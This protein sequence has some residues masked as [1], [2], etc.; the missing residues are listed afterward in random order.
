[1]NEKN[2]KF[3]DKK[4]GKRNFYKNKNLFKMEY[5]DINK[6]LVSKKASYGKESI[7]Y[8]IEDN[9]D[10]IIRPLCIKHPQMVGYV[11]HFKNN[12]KNSKRMNFKVSDK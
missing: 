10:D 4:V 3:E 6:I 8:Y 5:I 11:K 7:K 9:D 2:I 12:N 1:M